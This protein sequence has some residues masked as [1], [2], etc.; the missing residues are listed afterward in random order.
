M[1][2]LMNTSL[3]DLGIRQTVAGEPRDLS[4]LG[5][6][7]L[8]ETG[9]RLEPHRIEHLERGMQPLAG[10]QPPSLPAQPLAV[11]KVDPGKLHADAHAPEPRNTSDRLSPQRVAPRNVSSTEHSPARPCNF[12]RRP[13]P[14]TRLSIRSNRMPR[15]PKGLTGQRGHSRN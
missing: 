6:E 4:L 3:A 7:A 5:G 2:W 12:V 15:E 11:E 13:G 10:V 9:E 14:G 1:C 8:G